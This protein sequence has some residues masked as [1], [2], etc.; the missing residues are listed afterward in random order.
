[1]PAISQL[2]RTPLRRQPQAV[3]LAARRLWD[4]MRIARIT[5]KYEKAFESL[6]GRTGLKV[7]LGC[8][9]DIRTGWINIDLL[10]GPLPRIDP[11][12]QPDTMLIVRDLRTGLPL[13]EGSCEVIY[14]SH[15]FEHLSFADGIRLMTDC[16]R[17]LRAGGVFRIV[18]PDFGKAFEAYLRRDAEFFAPLDERALL[19]PFDGPYRTLVDYV[20]YSVYQYGEHVAIYDQE[21]LDHVLRT[22]GFA[23]VSRS[24]YQ[25]GVDI[26][27]EIRR[28][29][30]FYTE[31]IK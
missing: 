8:G 7:H 21:K 6:R 18:L 1:M 27:S 16:H 2:L 28:R 19:K 4:E 17:A 10:L 29:Y 3:R 13:D 14:S 22:V 15:F 30:S 5:R 31:A 12:Q 20:N 24:E 11:A 23:R 25:H 9:P 26:D